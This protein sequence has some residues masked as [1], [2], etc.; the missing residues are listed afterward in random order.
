MSRF[1]KCARCNQQAKLNST[2]CG[3]HEREQQEQAAY[4]EERAELFEAIDNIR[5]GDDVRAVLRTLAEK[6]LS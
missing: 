3:V 4:E 5:N 1:P 2:L 6:V